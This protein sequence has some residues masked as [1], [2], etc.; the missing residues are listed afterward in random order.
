MIQGAPKGKGLLKP[1]VQ[2]TRWCNRRQENKTQPDLH[3]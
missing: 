1:K 2:G 3:V